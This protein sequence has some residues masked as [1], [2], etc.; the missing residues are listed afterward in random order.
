MQTD[1]STAAIWSGM[2]VV[3]WR[4][5]LKLADWFVGGWTY[6]VAALCT[7]IAAKIAQDGGSGK[8]A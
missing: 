3:F 2:R 8:G 5:R 7:L 1:P 4:W 6:S